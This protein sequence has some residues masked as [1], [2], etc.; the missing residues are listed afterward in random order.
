VLAALRV[1]PHGL[2]FWAGSL[3]RVVIGEGGRDVRQACTN[4]VPDRRVYVLAL[5]RSG[6]FAASSPLGELLTY[7]DLLYNLVARD[8]KVR[9]R[10]SALG[11]LWTLLNPLLMMAVFTLVFRVM[12]RRDIENF[13]QFAL[14]GLLSWNFLAGSLTGALH[15]ITG[16]GNLIN[17][18]YFPREVLPL[19]VVIANLVNF[20][21]T[22]PL[23]FVLAIVLRSA[24]PGPHIVFLPAIILLQTVF[25]AGLALILA[26]LNV[27]FRDTGAF[28]E[29]GLLAWFFLT[30]VFYQLELLPN[31]SLLGLDIWRWVYILNPMAT[32]VTDYRYLVLYNIPPIR[33]TLITAV[34]AVTLLALGW[35][36]FRRV[37]PLFS[38]EV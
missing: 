26:A 16:N 5:P 29:V 12:T 23:Y 36:F 10:G 15:S 2:P 18:V 3:W 17:K 24:P 22:L 34:E 11:F 20:L 21:L 1:T 19:S 35:W 31:P 38:E 8:L 9:Y 30:P 14:L 32:I 27:L 7:R 4:L 33:M 28:L 13:P 37:A 25:V 6:I